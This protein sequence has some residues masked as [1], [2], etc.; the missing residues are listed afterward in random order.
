MSPL[1]ILIIDDEPD[2]FDV[3]ETLLEL[4]YDCQLHYISSGQE[5]I[6]SLDKFDPD[7]ILLD[8]MM[9]GMDGI[10]TCQAIKSTSK[11]NP[12]P[13]IM[14]TALNTTQNLALCLSK[15]ASDF[16]SKPI[17]S[18]E[19]NARVQSMLHIRQQHQQLERFNLT[20][21]SKVHERTRQLH[22]MI[23]YDELTQLPSR[24]FLIQELTKYIESQQLPFA[25]VS[26]DCD[27]FQLVNGSFGHS[28]TN[29][30]L[31][32]I[33]ARLK[34][35]LRQND[36]LIRMTE[37]KF[38]ILLENIEDK[39]I[40]E[41]SLQ[42]IQQCFNLPFNVANCD[43]FMT[44]CMGAVLVH[45][46]YR[47]P[48]KILQD[49]DTA[50]YQAQKQGKRKYQLFDSTMHLAM[51]NRLHLE[52]DLQR[53]LENNEFVPYYQPIVD[54][55][56]AK[57]KGFEALARWP[58]PKR[59]IVSP[60]EFIPCMEMTGL[61]V[62]FGIL[63]LK[64]ALQQLS[65]WHQQGWDD[66]FM[67]VN[68]SARQFESPTLLTDI[69]DILKETTLDPTYLKL[70]IT[71]STVMDNPEQAIEITKELR[72]RRIQISIDDFGT[73]YSSLGYLH[74]FPVNNLKIDRSFVEQ[75]QANNSEYHVVN[76]IITLSK[77]LG[78]SVIAEGLETF[79]QLSWLKDLNCEYGQGYFF[80]KP[81]SGQTVF[82][83]LKNS[84]LDKHF[85]CPLQV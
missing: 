58:H 81:L 54:L 75:I 67:S 17:N 26:L 50:M 57:V 62:P 25:V 21:E 56:T 13:I 38:C 76:T 55:K 85:E 35:T 84:S 45:D 43:I 48:E 34:R 78:L 79:E 29:Q 72:S 80:S 7:L 33:A 32:A 42:K 40:L 28:V 41:L 74:R 18:L 83:K 11:W 59:G 39:F 49:A 73:G 16:I 53:A 6:A 9:P 63:I 65:E 15:G 24:P 68:L 77:Q 60:T 23:F 71:E 69:D 14:V 47:T 64:Q 82:Q 5:A 30:L 36:L 46:T 66:L 20:L 2:N 19:L 3:I 61:I 8:V 1:S 31:I 27:Q 70:E 44:A 51:L 10:E 22:T 12:V 52:S 37:D 4:P